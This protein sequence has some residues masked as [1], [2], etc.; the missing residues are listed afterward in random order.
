MK[1]SVFVRHR[2]SF[3]M[4]IKSEA[5]MTIAKRKASNTNLKKELKKADN[6]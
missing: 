5:Y 1:I 3:P 2:A 6:H 4:I